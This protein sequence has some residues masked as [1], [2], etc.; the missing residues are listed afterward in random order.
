MSLIVCSTWLTS[1]GSE[2]QDMSSQAAGRMTGGVTGRNSCSPRR[3]RSE[4]DW[5][6]QPPEVGSRPARRGN[7]KACL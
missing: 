3:R 2:M 4:I 1:L 7:N 6:C 5:L